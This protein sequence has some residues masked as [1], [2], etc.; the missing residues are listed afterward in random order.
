MATENHEQGAAVAR[1]HEVLVM[2]SDGLAEELLVHTESPGVPGTPAALRLRG[3]EV[4]LL[5]AGFRA[6]DPPGPE[7]PTSGTQ[8]SWNGGKPD[9]RRG[10]AHGFQ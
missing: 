10:S 7:R 6:L 1:G 3:R 8:T 9:T 2:I 4:G 5:G